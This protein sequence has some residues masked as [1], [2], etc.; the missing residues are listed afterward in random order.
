MKTRKFYWM[1]SLM[2]LLMICIQT[3]PAQENILNTLIPDNKWALLFQIDEDFDISS[4]EGATISIK[5]KLAHKVWLRLGFTTSGDYIKNTTPGSAATSE[6]DMNIRGKINVLLYTNPTKEVKFYLGV[7]PVAGIMQTEENIETTK[8]KDVVIS[9]GLNVLFGVEWFLNES[10][11]LLA[12]YGS[13]FEMTYTYYDRWDK[14]ELGNFILTAKNNSTGSSF[15]PE[16]VKI[17]ISLYF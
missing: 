14:N 8:T 1:L 4:F 5:R 11:S 9:G 10:I 17:G 16:A 2:I 6:S 12:E 3:S 7:G 13:N 15:M